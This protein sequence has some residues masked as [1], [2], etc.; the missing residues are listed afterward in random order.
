[1]G[2]TFKDSRYDTTTV[3]ERQKNSKEKHNLRKFFE[4][5]NMTFEYEPKKV[6]NKKKKITIGYLFLFW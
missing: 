1:M 5:Q 4:T 3:K 6:Y 2:K